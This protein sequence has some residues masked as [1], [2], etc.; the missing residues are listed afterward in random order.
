MFDEDGALA[1]P[2]GCAS[3]YRSWVEVRDPSSGI[4]VRR[5]YA[6]TYDPRTGVAT[7]EFP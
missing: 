7:I 3:A 6:C 5:A 2:F 1:S 4:E